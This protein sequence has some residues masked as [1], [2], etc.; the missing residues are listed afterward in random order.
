MRVHRNLSALVALVSIQATDNAPP[1]CITTYLLDGGNSGD[2]IVRV[3]VASE[4]NG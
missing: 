1:V 2:F 4:G 3:G